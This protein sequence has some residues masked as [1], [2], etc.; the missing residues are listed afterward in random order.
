MGDDYEVN[1]PQA[2]RIH[3]SSHNDPPSKVDEAERQTG[4]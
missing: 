3:K 1:L 4:T 2:R